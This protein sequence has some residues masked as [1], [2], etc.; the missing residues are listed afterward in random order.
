MCQSLI[1][2][3]T[4]IKKGIAYIGKEPVQLLFDG[5]NAGDLVLVYGNLAMRRIDKSEAKE[6]GQ[7]EI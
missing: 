2:K 3:I 6:I 4:K 1:K 7:Y 5:A